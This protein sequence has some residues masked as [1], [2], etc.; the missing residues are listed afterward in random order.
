VQADKTP[1]RVVWSVSPAWEAVELTLGGCLHLPVR[2]PRPYRFGSNNCGSTI[3]PG[4]IPDNFLPSPD[5]YCLPF[6]VKLVYVMQL[7]T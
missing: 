6:L 1:I 4:Q 3:A 5:A 7:Q 2:G